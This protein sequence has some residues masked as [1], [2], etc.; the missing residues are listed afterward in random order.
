MNDCR[1]IRGNCVEV[2]STL[3]GE[4]FGAVIT[5]P[6]Y[7]LEFMGHD[8]DRLDGGF[9]KPGIGQ[10]STAWPSYGGDRFAGYNPTCAGC[11][12]RARGKQKCSC[13]VPEWKVKGKALRD[14]A[15]P[16]PG[17][18]GGFATGNKPSFARVA[19]YLPAMQ[20]WHY[21]WACAV[22]RVLK[23]GGYMVGF[24][25]T[26]TYHRLT[27]AVEDAGFEVR[28]CLMWMYGSGFPKGKGCLKPAWEPILLCRKP[29][30]KVLPL[31][32]DAC[33]IAGEKPLTT[34]GAGG[35]NG[36][37]GP[38]AAQGRVLDDGKGR[39]PANVILDQEA[40]RL[41]DEQTGTLHSGGFPGRRR[42]SKFGDI[43]SGFVGQAELEARRMD[44]GG[45]S[46]FFYCAKASRRERGEVNTHPTVKPLALMRWL[47]RLIT[48]PGGMVLDPFMGSG[49][50]GLACLQEGRKFVG[51]ERDKNY[52]KIAQRRLRTAH[53]LAA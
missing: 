15:R 6:P 46:R 17:N 12:G 21:E 36:R 20:A 10:R 33:R 32:I 49:T 50:T 42:S 34:R 53:P 11:K 31:G 27:C 28:D 35:Q 47:C 25:G 19:S 9:S 26:R 37:Y 39:W 16:K 22:F 5:D 48:P 3:D 29:G 40:G 1:L 2:L 23:P 4:M 43:F 30:K 45:A 41:L 13:A 8:W 52:F 24:G 44:A 38:I 51:I 18:L 7:G 14:L